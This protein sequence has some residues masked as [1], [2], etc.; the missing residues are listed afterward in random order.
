[1]CSLIKL[2]DIKWG[3]EPGFEFQVLFIHNVVFV[4]NPCV[5]VYY[6]S[7]CPNYPSCNANIQIYINTLTF[8]LEHMM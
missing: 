3:L 5:S 7:C 6:V 8:I 2:R 1:M 4:L